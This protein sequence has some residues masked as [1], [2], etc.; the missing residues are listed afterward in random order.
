MTQR[1]CA[2]VA[3]AKNRVIGRDNALP[4]RLPP[5]LK[6]FKALT[7][8]HPMIMGRKTFESIGKPLPGRTCI[9]LTKQAE[10]EVPGAIVVPSIAEAL[11]ACCRSGKDTDKEGKD[12]RAGTDTGYANTECFVIGGA[13]IFRQMLPLCDRL[14]ITEIQKDFDGDVLFPEFNREE[15]DETSREKHRW[16]DD[17]L[18]YHFVVLDRKQHSDV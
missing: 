5:D 13:E 14:Y 17:G 15:W 10:Y 9:I 18:A 7:M 16:D 11:I 3:M 4:W 12:I 2:L 8:G 6:R 1:L